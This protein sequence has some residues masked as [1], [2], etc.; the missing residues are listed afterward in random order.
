MEGIEFGSDK[1]VKFDVHVDDDGKWVINIF[2]SLVGS[3]GGEAMKGFISLS[4]NDFYGGED[5]EVSVEN[6]C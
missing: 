3:C 2:V 6:G 1:F 5:R 4:A